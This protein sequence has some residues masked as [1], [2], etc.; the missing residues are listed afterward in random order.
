MTVVAIDTS[1]GAQVAVRSGG[2]WFVAAEEDSRAHAE[3]L[4]QLLEQALGEA[5]L[6]ANAGDAQVESVVVG[7]GP[8]PFTGLRAGLVAA[9]VLARTCG[10]QEFG[11]GALELLARQYLDGLPSDQELVVVTDAR[12]REVYW[13]HARALGPDDVELISPAKVSAPGEVANYI[14]QRN[15]SYAGPGCAAYPQ[16]FPS[17]VGVGQV[18]V[19]VS[20]R[21]VEARQRRGVETFPTQPQYLRR[22]DI[23][24]GGKP[25]AVG[26]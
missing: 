8:A 7:T 13:A 23:H 22:P 17:P 6:P 10:A 26:K 9:H 21:V 3:R 2:Q 24:P 14:R 4:A 11:V 15:L 18:D 25:A 16:E 1:A 19:R 20:M 12:R 5:G